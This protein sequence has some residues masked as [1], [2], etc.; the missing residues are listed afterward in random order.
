[1][2]RGWTTAGCRVG[3]WIVLTV[4]L[5]SAAGCNRAWYRRQAD[6]EAYA[7]VREKGNHPHWEMEDFSIAVDPR[8][9]MYYQYS[10]D[11]PP[12]PQDDPY[13]NELMQCVDGKRGY[14]F[15]GDNGQDP[16]IDNPM[17]MDYLLLDDRGVL[18]MDSDDAVRLALLHSRTYQQNLEELY[19]SALD[20]SFERFR[21]DAQF[22]SANAFNFSTNSP[23]GTS[24][25]NTLTQYS[26]TPLDVTV[27]KSFTAGGT[28]V[29]GLAN[30]IIWSFNSAG[31]DSRVTTTLFDWTLIQPLLRNAGRDRVMERLTVAE[32]TLL[33]NVRAMEQYRQG[34]YVEIMTGRAA[35]GGPQRRG[36]FFGGAGLEG[37]TGVGGGGFGRV[38]TGGTGGGGF[39]G[40]AG[41]AQVGGYLGLLQTMQEIRNQEDNVDRLRTNLYRLEETLGELRTRSGEPQLVAN[42]LRQDLQVAQ[43]RQALF[44]SETSLLQARNGFEGTLDNFKIT[45]GLPP[46]LC[47]NVRDSFLDQFQLIDRETIELQIELE[48]VVA[49]FGAVRLRIAEHIIV[50]T[51]RDEA[52]P[53]RTRNVRVIEWYPELEQDLREL[54]EKLEPIRAVRQRL[55]DEH[56]PRT[57]RD[58]EKLAQSIPRRK[59]YLVRLRAGL[60]KSRE[61]ACPLLPVPYINSEIFHSERLEVLLEELRKQLG[62]LNTAATESYQTS[63]ADRDARIDKV[64]TEG[65]TYTPEKLF[66]ELY[67]GI[68]Y[69]KKRVGEAGVAQPADILVVLPADILALQLLQ[70]RARTESIELAPVDIRADEALE[71]ARR[72]R[73]DWMNARANLVD[74]WRLI[75][76][77][78]DQLQ[79]TLDI[80]FS[81]DVT[82]VRRAQ[83]IAP[84]NT[85]Q[86]TGTLRAGIQ[87]D[88]P[89]TRLAE[90]NTYRQAL[91]EY[92]QAR[93]NYY[94]FEDQIAQQL[95]IRVR[96]MLYNQLFFEL[97]RLAVLEAARQI[98][99]NEDIRIESELS[100]QATGATAARDAVSA[101]SD[102]L[103]AQN[104]FMGIWANFE[105]DRRSLDFAMGTLQIDSEGLWIDPGVINAAYG[106]IDPWLRQD[107][108]FVLPNNPPREELP[109][110]PPAP[111]PQ[112]A[113]PGARPFA[114]T[115]EATASGSEADALPTIQSYGG[116]KPA[117]GLEATKYRPPLVGP[118]EPQ[119]VAKPDPVQ[120]SPAASPDSE[121]AAS[122]A[123]PLLETPQ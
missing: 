68:L 15:W 18:V 100:G 38:G 37:F 61:E 110:P 13:S 67:D 87:F 96:V 23:L 71:I 52:D 90:R 43:A 122:P 95:R 8:S 80:V 30:S 9:R 50:R 72:Y 104:A 56:L 88:A 41:A 62:E 10:P 2:N 76:F 64:I 82:D 105:A 107:N 14:P 86:R 123:A 16:T 89:I 24:A 112:G 97:Q 103:D 53:M 12:M 115:S 40:G 102:L 119:T 75:Q 57:A 42:I 81:G 27:R 39:G 92:Q 70:A 83:D 28:F 77:N 60:D 19:L 31:A 116:L 63:L 66:D 3:T 114:F 78:A 113:L 58:L 4:V 118:P 111:L 29:A 101:L 94:Q 48:R 49:E 99:R 5:L 51:V 45:L 1:M 11:C 55:L 109:P 44:A 84:F 26:L 17:W 25:G 21:F 98:D 79:S 120:A 73:L 93:R 36:G 59:E 7:L 108:N 33:A 46:Q 91:L 69:P 121:N 20:V 6:A 74:S 65:M 54:K 35:G 85:G 47:V 117:R 34:F 22:F 106:E 32:R